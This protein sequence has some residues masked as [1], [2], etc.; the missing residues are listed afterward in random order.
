MKAYVIKNKEGKYCQISFNGWIGFA[1]ELYNAYIYHSKQGAEGIIKGHKY[2]LED[3]EV[4][5]ITVAEGDLEKEN[6]VLKEALLHIRNSYGCVSE[7]CV[8]ESKLHISS[9]KA[10]DKIRSYLCEMDF[11][12][13][14]IEEKLGDDYFIKA[15][16]QQASLVEKVVEE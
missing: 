15:R 5:E 14:D 1:S 9:E 16:K 13:D 10:V 11:A 12:F 6:R 8:D 3:C 2:Q 7:V 4:V